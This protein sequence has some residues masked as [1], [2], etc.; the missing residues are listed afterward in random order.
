MLA[1]MRGLYAGEMRRSGAGDDEIKRR[2]D[3]A[4][5]NGEMVVGRAVGELGASIRP[6]RAR[7]VRIFSRRKQLD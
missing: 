1:A 2:V 7:I 5:R 6:N 3:L 4:F